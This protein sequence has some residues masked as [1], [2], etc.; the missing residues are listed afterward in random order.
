MGSVLSPFP[1]PVRRPRLSIAA[2]LILAVAL[3]AA[4]ILLVDLP[5]PARPSQ[6]PAIDIVLTPSDAVM[7]EATTN[8]PPAP[9]SQ[10]G[11]AAAPTNSID[12]KPSGDPTR[13]RVSATPAPSAGP[14]QTLDSV[15]DKATSGDDPDYVELAR[16]IAGSYAQREL[17]QFTGAGGARS[18]RLTNASAR[19]AV[20]KA[21]L[22]LWQQKVER[23][24][25]ANYP[26]GRIAGELT[27]LA[28]IDFDGSLREARILEPSGHPTL[29]EAALRI[30]QLAA[31]FSHFPTDLHKDY[32][33]LEI[34]RQWR[35]ERRGGPSR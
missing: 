29:D 20:E 34:V 28:V 22:S 7:D 31:P 14:A 27:V 4:I 9:V 2:A 24:G 17:D 3:H 13:T 8:T 11:P 1:D 26:P 21:Y 33:R 12:Q 25:R 18:K 5:L 30:I 10:T 32:D 15:A 16:A 23:I 6:P 35:F 19:T